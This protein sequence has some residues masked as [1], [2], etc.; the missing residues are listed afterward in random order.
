VRRAC[1]LALGRARAFRSGLAVSAWLPK[2]LRVV[3]LE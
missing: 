3:G 2:G 1:E